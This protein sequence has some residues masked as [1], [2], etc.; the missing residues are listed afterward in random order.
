MSL[1][2]IQRLIYS[3]VL[4]I[5]L[6]ASIS[7]WAVSSL[8]R[9]SAELMQLSN[10]KEKVADLQLAFTEVVM[11]GNDYLITGSQAEAALY[12][13]LD[14][15]V[16]KDITIL[17]QTLRTESSKQLLEKIAQEYQQVRKIEQEI[18][19]LVN[20]VG[21]QQGAVLMEEM[22]AYA[23]KLAEQLEQLHENIRLQEEITNQQVNANL[24]NTSIIIVI[25]AL[26]ASLLGTVV[27]LLVKNAVIKPLLN[28]IDISDL[29]SQG[30]LTKAVTATAKGDIGKLIETFNKM[31]T[32]LRQLISRLAASADQVATTSQKLSTTSSEAVQ[33]VEQVSN[34]I[35]EVARGASEQTNLITNTTNT[36]SQVNNAMQQV[37]AGS[38]DQAHNASITANMSSQMSLTIIEVASSAESV[39]QSADL[40]KSAVEQGENAVNSTISGMN[41]IKD[42]VSEA[43]SKIK[44]LEDRSQQIGE[45]ILVI[46]GIAEQTNLLAL[47][48]AIEAARAGEQGKG[49]AVVAEEVRKLAD[50]SIS[51]T[52]EIEKL[53]KNIQALTF[54]AGSAIQEGTVQVEQGVNLA[55]SAGNALGEIMGLVRETY[56]QV[57]NISTAAQQMSTSSQEV[58]KAINSVNA[59]TQENT[60]STEEVTLASN[61]VARDMESIA[62]ITEETSAT[63]EEVSAS[64]EEMTASIMEI[65]QSSHTLAEMADELKQLVAGFKI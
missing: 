44:E 43:A 34:A 12:S 51:A 39:A 49:F 32:N 17:R 31:L 56:L 37:A 47:N 62:A 46:D 63:A 50:R 61:Q 21:N 14:Q 5:V 8:G 57:K 1:R 59:I 26:L 55:A 10:E 35:Q 19:A 24:R 64:A 30:N 65:S 25:A 18:L 4:V 13:K 20:P 45:I 42:S 38:Q 7:Y 29:I 2:A 54:T 28:V 23:S 58:V 3:L 27:S 15:E 36:L 40:T 60:A 33:V 9:D 48:A 53:I 41:I 52:K 16:Q 11:P 6:L 22:D